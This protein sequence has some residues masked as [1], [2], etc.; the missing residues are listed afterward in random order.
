MNNK[1]APIRYNVFRENYV[2]N[3][4]MVTGMTQSGKSLVGPVV[5]SLEKAENYRTDFVL[6]QIPM[7]HNIGMINEDAAIF[8]LRYGLDLMQYDNMLGRNTNFRYSDFSSIW[9]TK[10]PSLFYKRL[11]M[12]EGK[13]VFERIEKENPLFVLNFHNGVM[14]AKLLL[15]SFPGQKILHVVRNPV[16]LAY[17]WL[18]KGYGKMETYEVPRIRVLTYRYEGHILPYYAKGFEDE[19]LELGEMDRVIRLIHMLHSRHK[20]SFGML[21]DREKAQIKNI[22]FDEF[23]ENTNDNLAEICD[24]INSST[25]LY[26]PIVLDREKVP[27]KIDRNETLENQKTIEGLATLKYFSLLIGLLEDYE[28]RV[29]I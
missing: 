1:I 24:F 19:Y 27:R 12:D 22:Y 3:M 29:L 7:L 6:E 20:D 25:T 9:F 4:V 11:A 5:C 13:S 23:A 28:K 21:E 14:H 17:S 16:D 15:K 18:N 8:I 2:K 10:D 26:T